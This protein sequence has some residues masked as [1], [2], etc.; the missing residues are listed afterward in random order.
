[1]KY[2][3]E[4]DGVLDIDAAFTRGLIPYRTYLIAS[5]IDDTGHIA[6]SSDPRAV[7]ISVADRDYFRRHVATDS[8][9]ID[10]STPVALRAF[11]KVG[12]QLT[13]RVNHSNGTFAGMVLLSVDPDYFVDFALEANLGKQGVL[14]LVGTDGV[15]RARRIGSE[16]ATAPAELPKSTLANVA[17]APVGEF[18]AASAVDGVTRFFAYRTMNDYPLIVVVGRDSPDLLAGFEGRRV[19]YLGVAAAASLLIVVCFLVVTALAWQ[20]K[21][22]QQRAWASASEVRLVSKVF[23]TTADGIILSDPD[24]RILRVNIAFTRL[25][26]FEADEV[27]GLRLAES[28]FAP[29]DP[30][31]YE[32]RMRSLKKHGFV[33]GEVTRLRKDGTPLA[34]WVTATHVLAEDGA[35]LN[36]IRVF[37]DISTLKAT[38]LRLEHLAGADAL[39]GL[40]NR[41]AFHERIHQLVERARRQ[42]SQLGVM[43]VDLD[44]FKE[45]ND[46]HGHEWGDRVL[47]DVASLLEASVRSSD[48]VFRLGG[49][50]FTI[51]L[52][53]LAGPHDAIVVAQRILQAF[54]ECNAVGQAPTVSGASIGI[55]LFPSGGTDVPTLI[56]HADAAMYRA[57]S[58]GRN[59]YRIYTTVPAAPP[60]AALPA[61][62]TA[63]V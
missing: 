54:A 41:R 26:G 53:D 50:E 57:K 10:I 2:L 3:Y 36:Y 44:G 42:A 43:F 33:T 37:T 18:E 1:M 17:S 7:G 8:N 19:I 22:S 39:T 45:V 62:A 40:P 51:L 60:E 55:A 56:R 13:R 58:S 28:P 11:N 52:E 12:V 14:G 35:I 16:P 6:A 21:R 20:L 29:I 31:E 32:E 24:D 61:P 38:Q 4:R 30:A 49:D 48:T 47:Q 46:R 27:V 59:C 34:L 9:R 23:E 15:F 25:T 63:P 5:M